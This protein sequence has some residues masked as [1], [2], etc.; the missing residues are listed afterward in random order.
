[1]GGG[2]RSEGQVVFFRRV[3][4]LVEHNSRLHAGDASDGINLQNLR[5]VLGEIQNNGCVAALASQRSSRAAAKQ[6]SA[7]LAADGDG[8]NYGVIIAGENHS[9]GDLPVAGTIGAI[10]RAA[11]AIETHF[12]AKIA[13]ESGF[14]SGGI[15]GR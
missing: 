12:S 5:H 8:G 7:V 15:H 2:I 14:E 13:A 11:A 10:K 1:M 9:D 3:A 4:E 6:R